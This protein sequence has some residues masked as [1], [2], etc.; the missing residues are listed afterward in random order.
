MRESAWPESE[1]EDENLSEEGKGKER[2]GEERRCFLPWS[3]AA[4]HWQT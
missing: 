3:Q 1:Q 2:R 4:S